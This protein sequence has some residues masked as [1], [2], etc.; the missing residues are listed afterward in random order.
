MPVNT[1]EL[2][3]ERFK[4]IKD[5]RAALDAAGDKPTAEV[6]NKVDE[7]MKRADELKAQIDQEERLSA[8]Q[9]EL[10]KSA[11]NPTKP[12]P[13]NGKTA[14]S[15]RHADEYRAAFD[16]YLRS[17]GNALIGDE[18]RALQV[19]SQ[20]EGGYL[21]PQ[22]YET[23]IIKKLAAAGVMRQLASVITSDTDRNIPFEDTI[24]TAGWIDEEGTYGE[25]DDSFGKAVLSAYKG[26]RIVKVSD[27]LLRDASFDLEAYIAEKLGRAIGVL[28]E[29]AFVA[30]NGDKK[31]TGVM[32]GTAA[33]DAASTSAI[34]S[35][36]LMDLYHA[37]NPAY[38]TNAAWLMNDATAKVLRKLKNGTTGDYMWQPGLR[39][40]EPDILL[41]RPVYTSAGAP[42]IAA[43]AKVIAFGDFKYYQIVDR[44][45]FEMIRL[46][47]LYAASGQVG[48]RGSHR[49]DGKLIIAE[50]VK[51]LAMK[52]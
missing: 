8:A 34:T 22:S 1:N 2:R 30:G 14:R 28:Q 48:F 13:V 21:V 20:S 5:A 47:E 25:S 36:E 19:G 33:V 23:N 27:E 12:E 7:M 6:R 51:I 17:G 40:G 45:G 38:R 46:N 10:D 50:A 9:A 3:Q 43:S 42:T 15:F 41:G 18:A 4:L 11:N 37:L 26:G 16:K 49:T 31:P 52:A 35:D 24:G 32:T 39:N 29:A 44:S